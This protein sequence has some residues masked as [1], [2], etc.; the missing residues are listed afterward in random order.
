MICTTC[1]LDRE[2]TEFG[3][4]TIRG[5][6][7]HRRMCN[8]CRREAQNKRY[9]ENPEIQRKAKETSRAYILKTKYGLTPEDYETMV[10]NQGGRCLICNK[11][12]DKSLNVDHCHTTGKVRGLLCWD[13]NTSIGKLKDDPE[14]MRR[15]ASYVEG[16]LPKA[17]AFAVWMRE[18]SNN[19]SNRAPTTE[20]WN[21]IKSQLSATL[22]L[23]DKLMARKDI[24]KGCRS[25]V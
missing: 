13:C 8:P 2:D 25:S 15:A 22:A 9:A 24:D 7:A 4:Y 6:K 1:K 19:I 14:A 16:G 17:L 10:E 12:P 5:K 18:L 23:N 11:A 20:E 21:L 3:T